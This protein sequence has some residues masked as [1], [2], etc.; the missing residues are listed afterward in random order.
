MDPNH[1]TSIAP[2]GYQPVPMHGP[3][4]RE[5]TLM[6]GVAADRELL[7]ENRRGLDNRR[8]RAF[9]LDRALMAVFAFAFFRLIPRDP[10]SAVLCLALMASYLAICEMATGQTIG[11]RKLRVRTVMADGSVPTP[12]AAAARALLLPVEAGLLIGLIVYV[13]S[14][15]RRRI[16]D[17][18]AGTIVV[19]ANR[20]RPPSRPIDVATLRYP[21]AWAAIG[22]VL[23]TLSWQGR[24]SWSYRAQADEICEG[25]G[26]ALQTFGTDAAAQSQIRLQLAGYLSRLDPPPTW[27]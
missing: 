15:K 18:A 5:I 7:N 22:L 17:L 16:G 24:T 23:V 26:E 12:R 25:A 6:T 27:S 11:K 4:P 20:V 10:S 9:L 14:P 3:A 8:F 21:I 1:A 2:P 13:S 19:D